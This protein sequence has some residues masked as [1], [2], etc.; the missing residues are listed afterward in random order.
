MT[1]RRFV[2]RQRSRVGSRSDWPLAAPLRPRP[3]PPAPIFPTRLVLPQPRRLIDNLKAPRLPWPSSLRVDRRQQIGL[4]ALSNAPAF[5]D[6][7]RKNLER[8]Q[9]SRTYPASPVAYRSRANP[10]T[11]QLPYAAT[12]TGKTPLIP[13]NEKHTRG[14]RALFGEMVVCAK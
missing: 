5:A 14:L 6:R 10:I 4:N 2:Y 1:P 8:P 12:D 3:Q 9:R 7:S 11:H 13:R